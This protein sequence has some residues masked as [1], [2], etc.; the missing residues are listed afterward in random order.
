MLFDHANY[1]NV[2]FVRDILNKNNI[3]YID[4]PKGDVFQG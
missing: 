3:K 4:D 2:S 1:E